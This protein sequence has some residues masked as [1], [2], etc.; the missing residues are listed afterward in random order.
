ML[1]FRARDRVGVDSRFIHTRLISVSLASPINDSLMSATSITASDDATATL[2]S[3][4][5]L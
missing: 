5:L 4:K 2:P 3:R 1:R